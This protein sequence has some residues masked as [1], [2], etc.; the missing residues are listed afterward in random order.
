LKSLKRCKTLQNVE[1]LQKAKKNTSSKHE[2][3]GPYTL[4]AK[5]AQRN[6]ISLS[7]LGLS[8]GEQ[9]TSKAHGTYFL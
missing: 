9:T 1:K 6:T 7:H 5:G 4:A 3:L 8:S 2:I